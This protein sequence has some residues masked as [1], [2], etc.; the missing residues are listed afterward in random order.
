MGVEFLLFLNALA[1]LSHL[2][3]CFL[4]LLLAF[5]THILTNMSYFFADIPVQSL[6]SV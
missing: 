1:A 5:V 2:L 6:K 3:S 4:T